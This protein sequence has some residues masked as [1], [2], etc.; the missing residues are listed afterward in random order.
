MVLDYHKDILA[1]LLEED[2]LLIMSKGLGKL[3]VYNCILQVPTHQMILGLHK[4]IYSLIRLH[5]TSKRIVFVLNVSESEQQYILEELTESGVP[6]KDLPRRITT[7]YT[8][9]ER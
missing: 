6:L 9:N 8:T 4:I 3:F 2:S 1:T 5:C 7:E